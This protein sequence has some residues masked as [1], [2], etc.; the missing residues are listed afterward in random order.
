MN[1]KNVAKKYALFIGRYQTLHE[2]HKYLFRKKIEQGVP[3]L[4]AIREVPLDERN[5][6]KVTDVMEMFYRDDETLDWINS[7]M[8]KMIVIPDI[9]GV[10]YGRDV[11]YN[12]EQLA[13]PPEVASISA[14]A[15]REE[16]RKTGK[17]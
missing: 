17:L 4:V 1:Q 10:Y 12:V 7:Q 11:G 13:V 3:V 5:P 15:I 9:E 8:M 6:Y 16:K 2:G 14:T